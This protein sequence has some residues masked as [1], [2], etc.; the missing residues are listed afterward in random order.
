MLI[1]L[2]PSVWCLL[3]AEISAE[4]VQL[5]HPDRSEL[6]HAHLLKQIAEVVQFGRIIYF[7]NGVIYFQNKHPI[8]AEHNYFENFRNRSYSNCDCS[9]I[10]N[11]SQRDSANMYYSTAYKSDNFLEL[12]PNTSSGNLKIESKCLFSLVNCSLDIQPSLFF[13]QLHRVKILQ[14]IE[15]F[16]FE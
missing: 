16:F 3:C 4:M 15:C 9:N 8:N 12:G 2:L 5:Y 11:M 14:C 6:S 13:C 7:Q 1:F 10:C